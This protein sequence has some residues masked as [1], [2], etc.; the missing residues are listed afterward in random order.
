MSWS[1]SA[2]LLS[3]ESIPGIAFSIWRWSRDRDLKKLKWPTLK[4]YNSILAEARDVLVVKFIS[5][6]VSAQLGFRFFRAH[7][8]R[9][10]PLTI[11]ECRPYF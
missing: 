8:G 7:R 9:P 1:A 6:N 2:E 10:H 3:E 4:G 11:S 5:H